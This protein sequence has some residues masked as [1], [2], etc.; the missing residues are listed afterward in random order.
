MT[1]PTKLF[2]VG[3]PGFFDDMPV[4]KRPSAK[5]LSLCS[6]H[7]SWSPAHSRDDHYLLHSGRRNWFL[8]LSHYNEFEEKVDYDIV[9]SIE[10][11]GLDE[12]QAAR[13]LITEFLCFCK[14]ESDLDC[15][16]DA[17]T[18]WLNEEKIDNISK[19]VWKD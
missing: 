16:H 19:A 4:P 18:G 5:C 2:N 7:W 17:N 13:V 10:K 3:Y 12:E 6:L 9:A 8:W 1:S 11:N 14:N 15:F